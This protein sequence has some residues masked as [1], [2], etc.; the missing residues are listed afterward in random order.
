MVRHKSQLNFCFFFLLFPRSFVRCFFAHSY[1]LAPPFDPSAVPRRTKCTTKYDC[2]LFIF[3]GFFSLSRVPE[4]IKIKT[5]VVYTGRCAWR[6]QSRVAV[7]LYRLLAAPVVATNFFISI[8]NV[9]IR[10]LFLFCAYIIIT[11][12]YASHAYR[13]LDGLPTMMVNSESRKERTYHAMHEARWIRCWPYV[14]L[15]Q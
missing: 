2:N 15:C 4:H 11:F 8:Y 10:K 14:I 7:C 5:N 9:R 6:S 3:P 13:R 1:L 12:K